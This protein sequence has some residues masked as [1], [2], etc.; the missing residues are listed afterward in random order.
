MQYKI[1]KP[2]RF[3]ETAGSLMSSL[4]DK[5]LMEEKKKSYQIWV[6]LLKHWTLSHTIDHFDS[7][8]IFSLD[9][10][11]SPQESQFGSIPAEN[12]NNG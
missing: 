6:R 12:K 8:E 5:W 11:S 1:R 3:A 4:Q 7:K 2:S 10:T 9:I